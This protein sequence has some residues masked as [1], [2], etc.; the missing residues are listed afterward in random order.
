ML[1][2]LLEVVPGAALLWKPQPQ[3][4]G[5][6]CDPHCPGGLVPVLELELW[7]SIFKLAPWQFST[8]LERIPPPSVLKGRKNLVLD[9]TSCKMWSL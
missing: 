6:R 5:S 1:I 3:R 7:D 2:C 9:K 4:G 8:L